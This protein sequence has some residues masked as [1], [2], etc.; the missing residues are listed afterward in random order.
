MSGW[1]CSGYTVGNMKIGLRLDKGWTD[2][3]GSDAAM[4]MRK[5]LKERLSQ[6]AKSKVGVQGVK[7]AVAVDEEEPW[8]KLVEEKII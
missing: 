1:I 2:P 7:D 6:K 8:K 3:H 5:K 4:K